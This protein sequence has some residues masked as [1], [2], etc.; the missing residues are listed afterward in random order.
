M[1]AKARK[2]HK[3]YPRPCC[4]NCGVIYKPGQL[5]SGEMRCPSCQS[6][7]QA[8]LFQPPPEI[9]AVRAIGTDATLAEGAPNTEGSEGAGLGES[10]CAKHPLNVAEGICDRCGTFIC[11]LCRI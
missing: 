1:A 2:I 5:H 3:V 6:T 11:A 8:V 7:F 10:P 9:I 4:P